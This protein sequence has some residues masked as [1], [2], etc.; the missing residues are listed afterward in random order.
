MDRCPE[1]VPAAVWRFYRE[2]DEER[3]LQSGESLLSQRDCALIGRLFAPDM[4]RTWRNFARHIDGPDVDLS[5]ATGSVYPAAMAQRGCTFRDAVAEMDWR[6][7]FDLLLQV[8]KTFDPS[9]RDAMRRAEDLLPEI[10]EVAEDLAAKLREYQALRDR[11]L[12]SAPPEFYHLG[13]LVSVSLY[14]RR[15]DLD[16]DTLPDEDVSLLNTATVI[17]ELANSAWYHEPECFNETATH[18]HDRKASH[19]SAWVRHFDAMWQRWQEPYCM[20]AR[21]DM[22]N[23]DL[24]RIATAVLRMDVSRETVKQA[25]ARAKPQDASEAELLAPD[26]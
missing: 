18:V 11:H 24:A 1:Y 25:R 2:L 10:A 21:F 6:H 26:E 5:R 17:D 23:T 13:E 19:V 9:D 7:L 15:D 22:S 12:I 16:P 8:R 20:V 3:D 4:A 14:G